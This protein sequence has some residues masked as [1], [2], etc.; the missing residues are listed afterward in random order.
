MLGKAL[1]FPVRTGAGRAL[2]GGLLLALT[3]LLLAATAAFAHA[4]YDHS[5][6]AQGQVLPTSPASVDIYT[7]QDMQ[8][9]AG[10]YGITVFRNDSGTPGAEVDTGTT[11]MDDANRRHFS[12]ALQPNLPPGRYLV[13]FHNVS[14][15]D[16]DADHG[17][18][19]FYIGSPPTPA[20]QA[21]DSKLQ[22]TAAVAPT[23]TPSTSASSSSSSHTAE[24]VISAIAIVIVLL[25][26]A[27]YLRLRGPRRRL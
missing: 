22:I 11:V 25:I 21:L 5:T 26:A 8:K 19:A 1:S 23:P 9:E 15:E 24:Y 16:G 13:S 10:A 14:D 17:Q 2:A 12:V 3:A 27:S 4:R 6:P 20:Q 7:E 18:F